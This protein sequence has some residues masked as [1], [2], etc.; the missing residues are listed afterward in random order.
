MQSNLLLSATLQFL[1]EQLKGQCPPAM[2]VFRGQIDGH[3]FKPRFGF[4]V[5]EHI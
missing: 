4:C 5:Y 1:F 3:S 2:K